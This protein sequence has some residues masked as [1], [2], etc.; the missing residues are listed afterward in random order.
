MNRIGTMHHKNILFLQGPMGTFFK[1]IDM[2]FREKGAR[3]YKIGFNTGDWFFSKKD[4]YTPYKGTQEEWGKFI[5]AFLLKHKIDKVFLFGDCRFY[6][7][8]ALQA[9]NELNVNVFVFEEGYLRPYFI[10]ME[11][12]GV[13]DFSHIPREISFYEKLDITQFKEKIILDVRFNLYRKVLSV[14]TYYILKDV[15]W[16][17]YPY[18]KHHNHYNFISETFFGIRNIIRKNMYKIT[19]RKLS[20]KI[21]TD[22]I[23]NYY[24]VPLQTYNDFQILEHSNFSSIEEFIEIVMHSFAKNAPK[25]TK[26]IIKHH[27][28][29]RGRKNYVQFIN[30]L[31]KQLNIEERT[32]IA[33]DLHIPS[34]LKNAIGTVTINS[35]VGISSLYHQT[36][37]KTLGQAI[38]DIEHLT[39]KNISLAKFWNNPEKPDKVLF[40]KFR[41][42]LIEHTQ[43]NGN[44]YGKIPSEL[45]P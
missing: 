22:Y 25:G 17:L 26:I 7:R 8:V 31:S 35:T 3:T 13:N 10:T 4:N 20:K 30:T 23:K 45:L 18:Y 27:P 29:D 2:S 19:E 15:F 33:H 28:M 34:C 32:I 39:C 14:A 12:H 1:D 44:F 41:L 24:F 43:L 11:Q 9:S 38:Y 16:F 42:Y 6:Q 40:N 21:N 36:P 5:Y 37:T